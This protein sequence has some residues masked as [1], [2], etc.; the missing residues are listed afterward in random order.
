MIG[1][2]HYW[3]FRVG[4]RRANSIQRLS[5]LKSASNTQVEDLIFCL[6]LFHKVLAPRVW[7]GSSKELVKVCLDCLLIQPEA[8]LT[9]SVLPWMA[10]EGEG[11]G[12][13]LH[14]TNENVQCV[15]LGASR[16]LNNIHEINGNF[17]GF[18]SGS[19]IHWFQVELEF[20][21]VGSS[22]WGRKPQYLEKNVEHGRELPTN[23]SHI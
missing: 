15:S 16:P 17:S 21:K 2:K 20:G 22:C 13:Y 1:H 3:L 5:N 12:N 23:S 11:Y 14:I 7:K 4:E 9:W 18:Q 10:W 6:F 19:F 8:L